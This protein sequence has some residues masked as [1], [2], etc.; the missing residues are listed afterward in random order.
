LATEVRLPQLGQTMQEGTIV[1]YRVNVGDQ[2]NKGD[3]I[4]E[5]E[6]DKATMEIESPAQGYVKHLLVD[7][8]RTLPVGKPVLILAGKDE[9]V[10]DDFLDSLKRE[11]LDAA[12]TDA[13]QD[14][15]VPSP[16]S[17]E[18]TA[19]T[20]PQ[21]ELKLGQTVI[22]TQKQKITAQKMLQSKREIPCFY[23]TVKADVTDLVQLR[24]QL[25]QSSDVRTSYHDFIMRAL[26][27]G[28]RK[29]PVMTGRF[30]GNS[31]EL[32]DGIDIGMAI[33]APDGLVAPIV[34]NVDQKNIAQIAQDS[35]S[36]IEKALNNKLTPA[37]LEGG[38]ITISNLGPFGIESFIPIVVPGQCS[39]LGIGRIADTCVP[40]DTGD[41]DPQ[42]PGIIVRKLLSLTLSVDHRITNGAYAGQFLDFT[43]KLLEDTSNFA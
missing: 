10:S 36:L 9:K 39:I 21:P 20:V 15:P 1:E 26:A 33:T 41:S 3:C 22:L 43:R 13:P 8:G 2:V 6:T 31:I 12:K 35:E 7:V 28:L 42:K 4:F 32:A 16:A 18:F 34:R 30:A 37:D 11:N 29:F 14:V 24:A 38:C 5:I 19:S 27:V 40:N 25:N 17:N 23:L